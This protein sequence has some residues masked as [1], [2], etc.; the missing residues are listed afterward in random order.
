VFTIDQ[1][2]RWTDHSR[3][4]WNG[5][6]HSG[7]MVLVSVMYG[8]PW[9]LGVAAIYRWRG[10]RRFRGVWMLAPVMGFTLWLLVLL[11]VQPPTPSNRL[12]ELS[13]VNIPA[14]ARNLRWYHEGSALA[15]G[16]C[17]RWYFEASP[18]SIRR[19]LSELKLTRHSSVGNNG[20]SILLSSPP[21]WADPWQW[22][23]GIIQFSRHS[24]PESLGLN[25]GAV[26]NEPMTR[27][28]LEFWT[29]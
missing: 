16:P 8:T 26:T 28:H 18:D 2:I 29:D 11:V 10:W 17:D 4:F 6:V 1:T 3:G 14:D 27:V 9:L 5:L 23:G 20:R 15:G 12:R 24:A 21:G 7:L 25:W 13:G 22:S 19:F